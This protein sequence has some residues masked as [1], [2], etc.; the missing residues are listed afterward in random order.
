VTQDYDKRRPPDGI[1][2]WELGHQH[3]DGSHHSLRVQGLPPEQLPA[4]VVVGF[5]TAMQTTTSAPLDDALDREGGAAPEDGQ[6]VPRRGE[7]LIVAKRW[8][9]RLECTTGAHN[10]HA[11]ESQL[12]I[13]AAR[14]GG[15]PLATCEFDLSEMVPKS[16]YAVIGPEDFNMG[17]HWRLQA[18]FELIAPGEPEASELG[19]WEVAHGHHVVRV[20]GPAL[21]EAECD[22]QDLYMDSEDEGDRWDGGAGTHHLYGTERDGEDSEDSLWG[23]LGY[24]EDYSQPEPELEPVPIRRPQQPTRTAPVTDLSA[25]GLSCFE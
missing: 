6:Y 25:A 13:S 5:T 12:T 8:M 20:G 15:A 11:A 2:P 1:M 7:D 14:R 23:G 22:E 10:W 19:R 4:K 17:A 18:T 24:E 3:L 21:A 16:G 9:R